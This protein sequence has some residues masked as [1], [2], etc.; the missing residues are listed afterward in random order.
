[1]LITRDYL[2]SGTVE[3]VTLAIGQIAQHEHGISVGAQATGGR[4]AFSGTTGTAAY[5]TA[6]GGS[7][8]HTH[9]LIDVTSNISSN[10][11]PYYNLAYIMRV[12]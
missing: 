1:M 12:A 5:S 3:P 7:Q 6:S 8:S 2:V 9:S 11:P 4:N 10:L